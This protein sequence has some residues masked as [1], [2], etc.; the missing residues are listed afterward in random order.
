MKRVK[1]KIITFAMA[2][3]LMVPCVF[4]LTACGAHTHNL[5]KV[6]PVE[7]TCATDGNTLYYKC[8]CGKYF[9][10]EEAK[11]EIKKD[12]WVVAKTGHRFDNE[13]TYNATHHWKKA[14]CGHTTEKGEYAEHSLTDDECSCG[15]VVN[16]YKVYDVDT[17]NEVFAGDYLNNGTIEGENSIYANDVLVENYQ[18]TVKS[19]ENAMAKTM[20]SQGQ[21][22][23]QYLVKQGNAW[24]AINYVDGN[25]YGF[26]QTDQEVETNTFAGGTGS[27]FIDNFEAFEFNEQENCYI[28]ND[29]Q[30][31]SSTTAEYVKVYIENGK[32][33]KMEMKIAEGE[34]MYTISEQVFSDYGTTVVDNIPQWTP[35]D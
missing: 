10:D 3:C 25:W 6:S 31:D 12:S 7:A 5:T 34:E 8:D 18:T 13:W 4:A 21:T 2:I 28:A 16:P 26:E 23:T 24:Y 9:S 11:K 17:W 1:T 35:I 30:L 29:Y 33:V 14:T 19:T 22:L 32:L 20:S 15:Y 27:S